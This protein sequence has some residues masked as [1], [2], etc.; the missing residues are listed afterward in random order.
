MSAVLLFS[1]VLI[2]VGVYY[3]PELVKQMKEGKASAPA[4]PPAMKAPEVPQAAEAPTHHSVK[5]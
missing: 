1:A 3:Y 2:G 4:A 5:F